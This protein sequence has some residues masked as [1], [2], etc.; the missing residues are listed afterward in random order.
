MYNKKFIS[1]DPEE[2]KKLNKSGLAKTFKCSHSY[3]NRVLALKEAPSAPKAI[4]IIKTAREIIDTL[5]KE[6]QVEAER[7]NSITK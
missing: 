6:G 3:V 1:L 5:K 7:L 2:I 4:S